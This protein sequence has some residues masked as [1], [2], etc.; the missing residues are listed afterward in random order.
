VSAAPPRPASLARRLGSAIY[1][2]LITI[3]LAMIATFPFLLAF[4]D[5]THGWKRHL[6][7]AWI[8]AAIGAYYM[9]F[10]TRGGQTLPMKT[11]RIRL[12][13]SDTG[14][15]VNA[16]R[17]V[18]RYLL[19]VLGL[20]AVGLGFAW[21]LVDRDR[22]FLHDR[23]AGTMLALDERPREPRNAAP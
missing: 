17:A 12:V 15:P 13:R 8:V 22:L 20:A 14:G 3:A 7:Q 21:A 2:L 19:A 5:A 10:W 23:L 6:L 11:W 16:G 1:D 4:G 18:H 9:V